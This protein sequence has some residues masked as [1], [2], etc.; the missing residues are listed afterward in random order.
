[1]TPRDVETMAVGDTVPL[2]EAGLYRGMAVDVDG[3][4]WA[5]MLGGT[6]AHK[7]DPETYEIETFTG[8]SSPYTYSDMSGGQLSNV[9][10]NPPAG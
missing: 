9:V 3:Y 5:V 7:I 6:T 8:L 1:M 4:I 10:C 2:P